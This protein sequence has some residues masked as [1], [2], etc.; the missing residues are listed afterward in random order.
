MF[1]PKK[2]TIPLSLTIF[3]SACTKEIAGDVKLTD[4]QTIPSQ[5][6]VCAETHRQYGEMFEKAI[7]YKLDDLDFLEQN[8]EK[9][10]QYAKVFRGIFDGYDQIEKKNAEEKTEEYISIV[11]KRR[12]EEIVAMTQNCTWLLTEVYSS[13]AIAN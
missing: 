3:L 8:A 11:K 6:L 5:I 10:K 9:N 4:F 13:E 7:E 12:P 2:I 1:R